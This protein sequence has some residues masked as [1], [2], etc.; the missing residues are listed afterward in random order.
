MDHSSSVHDHEVELARCSL[1]TDG[2]HMCSK[3]CWGSM[4]PNYFDIFSCD[5]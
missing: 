2:D 1:S 5:I 3:T 4:G